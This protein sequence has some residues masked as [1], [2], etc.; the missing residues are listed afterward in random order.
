[1]ADRGNR[2][3]IGPPEAGDL[4][5]PRP[6]TPGPMASAVRET[7]ESLQD[8]AGAMVEQRR[9]NAADARAFRAAQAEGRVLAA[10]PL[11]AIRTDDL[12]RDRMDL[13][14]VAGSDEMEELKASIRARGQKEPIEVYADAAGA[15][16][17]KKGWR[18]LSALRQL[19]AETGEARFATVTARVA[20][21]GTDRVAL[22]LDMVEENVIREDLSFA[23]M[24]QLAIEAAR[25]PATGETDPEAM[26]GRLYGALHKMK[27]SY[28]RAFV[29][30]LQALGEDLKFPRAVPRN[31][32]VEV[33]R[34]LREDPGG[35]AG[36]RARLAAAA[37]PEAQAA[38]LARHLAAART[39]G[40][41]RARPAVAFEAPGGV[42]VRLRDGEIRLSGGTGFPA[43]DRASLERAVAA[44]LAALER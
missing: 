36:L 27:R 20:G 32:G 42:R 8:S 19:L 9:R 29:G 37:G 39:G 3:G 15:L 2:F 25:D 6:R 5:P 4:P 11:A 22:Y 1:M 18:R 26:V 21:A 30:L 28:I 43:L 10:L 17:L 41:G 34:R 23:E 12:P 31:L 40:T 44:F 38:V 33:A 14:A 24:A 35:I 13:E 16:Q 7:A